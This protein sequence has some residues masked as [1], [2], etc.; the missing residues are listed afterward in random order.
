MK[1]EAK[2]WTMA[3]AGGSTIKELKPQLMVTSF[4]SSRAL[5]FRLGV[6]VLVLSVGLT[7]VFV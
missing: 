1:A 5:F 3:S 2:Q 7:Q 6:M 4:S